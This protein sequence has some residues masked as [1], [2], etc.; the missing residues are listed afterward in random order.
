M[1]NRICVYTCV[2]RGFL[3]LN[4]LFSGGNLVHWV[5]YFSFKCDTGN[6]SWNILRMKQNVKQYS[7]EYCL[8]MDSLHYWQ[9]ERPHDRYYDKQF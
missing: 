2:R 5:I 7:T 9:A 6:V 4:R 8:A 1:I 3:L